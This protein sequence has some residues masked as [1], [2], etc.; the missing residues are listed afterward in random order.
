MLWLHEVASV[1]G[2]LIPISCKQLTSYPHFADYD[3]AAHP[4][5]LILLCYLDYL[6]LVV[7]DVI[8]SGPT[9]ASCGGSC[10]INRVSSA[11][12]VAI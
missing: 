6:A 9:R 1:S 11:Q 10:P 7:P 3:D 4:R 5:S 8:E 12:G 2:R